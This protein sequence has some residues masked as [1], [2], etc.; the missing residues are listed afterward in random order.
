MLCSLHHPEGQARTQQQGVGR[1]LS[2]SSYAH[3]GGRKWHCS[4]STSLYPPTPY[5]MDL[6]L[7]FP[8]SSVQPNHLSFQN[9]PALSTFSY[10]VSVAPGVPHPITSS[11]SQMRKQSGGT[12]LIL[13][14]LVSQ[15]QSEKAA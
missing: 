10:V 15:M 1:A 13:A 14:L 2:I 7:V 12:C 5:C 8:G 11:I 3:R 4:L 6:V 9:E